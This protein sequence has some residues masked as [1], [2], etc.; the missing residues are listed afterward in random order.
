M[1]TAWFEKNG[2]PFLDLL[3]ILRGVEPQADG[4]RHLYHRF[5]T[6]FNAR[7]NEVTAEALANFLTER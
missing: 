3:P 4:K 5:D 2:I 7:G 6:H 1:I